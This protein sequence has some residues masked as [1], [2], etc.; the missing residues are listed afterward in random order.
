MTATLV[1]LIGPPGV[2]KSTT[3]NRLTAGCAR[4]HKA[5]PV[6]HEA[7]V[8]PATADTVAVELGK[9]RPGFP[10]TDTL[11][12]NVSPTAAAWIAERPHQLVVA[13]GDRL[14]HIGFLDAARAA[15]YEVVLAYLH[16]PDTTV[17]ARCAQRGSQQ[18]DSWRRGR[19]TKAA[20]LADKAEAAGHTVLRVDTAT[21]NP[22]AVATLLRGL[23]PALTALP[24]APA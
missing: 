3:M 17:D 14:A 1:Y 4:S 13:E 15:G 11:P 7:L 16:A 10:G 9:A 5:K 24:E 20:N 6:S 19:A 2:G 12:M 21:A 22:A 18:N 23:V 8:D